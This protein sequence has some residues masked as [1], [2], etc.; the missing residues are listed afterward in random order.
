[1]MADSNNRR[2]RD[3]LREIQMK[4]VTN[5]SILKHL[6]DIVNDRRLECLQ[7]RQSIQQEVKFTK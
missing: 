3:D 4:H 7:L 1:M 5:N 6:Q 2:Y